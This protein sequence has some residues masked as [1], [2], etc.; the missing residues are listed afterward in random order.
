MSIAS[1][2]ESTLISGI[3]EAVVPSNVSANQ[4]YPTGAFVDEELPLPWKKRFKN[5][6]PQLN[7]D[8]EL[9][10]PFGVVAE[11]V[12]PPNEVVD[13]KQPYQVVF[14]KHVTTPNLNDMTGIT[15][16]TLD[17]IVE[18]CNPDQL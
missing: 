6:I 1:A 2:R 15:R 12:T 11:E 4:G 18:T 5:F 7:I 3:T 9:L 16:Q 14:P 13:K 8:E 17:Q 10:P